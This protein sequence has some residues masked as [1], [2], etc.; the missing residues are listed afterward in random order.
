[1]KECEHVVRTKAIQRIARDWGGWSFNRVWYC[2]DCRTVVEVIEEC[3]DSDATL[4]TF[5]LEVG[6]H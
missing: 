5:T 3:Y 6:K 1:M 2:L 4:D